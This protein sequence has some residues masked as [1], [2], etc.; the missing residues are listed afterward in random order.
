MLL[1]NLT[2]GFICGVFWGKHSSNSIARGQWN[3]FYFP[4]ITLWL[5]YSLKSCELIWPRWLLHGQ[6]SLTIFIWYLKYVTA[7]CIKMSTLNLDQG[8]EPRQLHRCASVTAVH[9]GK[10]QFYEPTKETLWG[11]FTCDPS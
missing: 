5:E 6:A 4:P 7:F 11:L 2:Q 9:H 10:R 3:R 1:L 8:L